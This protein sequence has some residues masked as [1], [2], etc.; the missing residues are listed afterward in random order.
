MTVNDARLVEVVRR[1]FDVHFVAHGNPD[2]ILPH[3]AGNMGENFV[4]VGK[5]DA[6]HR[7]WKHLRHISGQ[8]YWLFFRHKIIEPFNVA[9]GGRKI[10]LFY[11]KKQVDNRHVLAKFQPTMK[12]ETLNGI[13]TFLLGL[14]VVAGVILALRLVNLT[15]NTRT[16]QRTALVDNALMVRAQSLYADAKAYNKQY[17]NPQLESILQSVETKAPHH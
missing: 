2:E 1:H 11:T 17:P 15:R 5:S 10:N 9:G 8:F 7:A 13:L 6:K 14:L 4:S 3:F 12:S 16:L